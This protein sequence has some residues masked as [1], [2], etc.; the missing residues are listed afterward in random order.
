VRLTLDD[1]VARFQ[2][3]ASQRRQLEGVLAMLAQD[4]LAPTTMTSREQ[5]LAVHIADSLVA[6]ELPGV[7]E[8]LRVADIG[9]GAGFPG[10]ALAIALPAA[11]VC[12][13][14]SQTRRCDFLM[15][16]AASATIS[17]ATVVCRRAEDWPGGLGAHDLVTARALGAAVVVLEYAAPLLRV[18]GALVDWR[19]RRDAGAERRARVVARKLGLEA[20]EIRHVKPFPGAEHHHL[21]LYAKVAA[22][23]GHLPRRPGMARKR[24]LTP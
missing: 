5:A 10:L 11:R 7:G 14:E 3:G 8:A 20:R 19:G 13:V 18:G 6:L 17:N 22:T 4:S 24:P 16:L 2:L 21:H 23:P 1:V 9:S 12:L 15:R